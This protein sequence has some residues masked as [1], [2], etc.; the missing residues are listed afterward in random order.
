MNKRNTKIGGINLC[1]MHAI[2]MKMMF[3]N[4]CALLHEKLSMDIGKCE[5]VHQSER[6]TFFMYF[7]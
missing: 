4:A 2:I 6:C 5:K 1:F 7:T 3:V